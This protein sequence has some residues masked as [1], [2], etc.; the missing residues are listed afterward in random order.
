M[1]VYGTQSRGPQKHST[2]IQLFMIHIDYDTESSEEQKEETTTSTGIPTV[3]TV[4]ST[5]VSSTIPTTTVTSVVTT[6]VNYA[7]VVPRYIHH[8][9][10]TNSVVNDR[11]RTW[12]KLLWNQQVYMVTLIRMGIQHV[13]PTWYPYLRD[14]VRMK[15]LVPE[16]DYVVP[17]NPPLREGMTLLFMKPIEQLFDWAPTNFINRYPRVTNGMTIDSWTPPNERTERIRMAIEDNP[18]HQFLADLEM[19]PF[20]KKEEI[21]RGLGNLGNRM[22]VGGHNDRYSPHPEA[23]DMDSNN[24]ISYELEQLCATMT[25]RPFVYHGYVC[26]NDGTTLPQYLD[27]CSLWGRRYSRFPGCY[28]DPTDTPFENTNRLRF[29]SGNYG[30]NDNNG[31]P[32]GGN[33]PPTE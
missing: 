6:N 21:H 31:P 12:Y 5:T 20:H 7:A 29:R 10:H 27:R 14:Y 15:N 13:M 18:L 33:G 19:I 28:V 3:S 16:W 23:I 17:F 22:E 8:T 24:S 9:Y 2:D 1:D 11:L 30:N 26:Y 4:A 25:P 32:D